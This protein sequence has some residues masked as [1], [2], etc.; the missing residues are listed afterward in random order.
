MIKI[1]YTLLF[2]AIL[3]VFAFAAVSP[4][5]SIKINNTVE[6]TSSDLPIFIINTNGQEIVDDPRI[7]AEMG[8][9]NNGPGKRNFL[10][11]PINGYNGRIAIEL[12]GSATGWYPKGQYRFETQDSL[13]ENLNVSLLGMP[14]END[15]I[16]Y[17]PYTDDQSLIRNVLAYKLSNDIGRYASR[18]RFCELVLDDD[19]RGLYI[20]MEKIKRDNDRVDIAKQDSIDIANGDI[21][22]GY[23]IKVDKWAGEN[24]GGWDGGNGTF[25][26]YHYPKADKIVQQQQDY[27]QNFM[28]SFENTM[29]NL[30]KLGGPL[31]GYEQY[32]DVPSFIDHFLLNEFAKNVDA[33]RIS[34]FLYKQHDSTGG[35]LFA[36]PAW[37]FNLSFGNSWYK[38]DRFVTDTWQ[39]DYSTHIRP[40]DGYRVPF[41]WPA[42]V[43]YPACTDRIVLRWNELK[44]THF[45]KNAIFSTIDVLADS[46]KE[47]R[48]R[49][50]ARWP[51]TEKQPYEDEITQ[52]KQ[53][54]SDRWDFMETNLNL[55][56]DVREPAKQNLPGRYTLGENYPN[57]FNPVTR[58][59]YE[60][61]QKARVRINI[62]NINGQVVAT[63]VDGLK[64]AGSYTVKFDAGHLASGIYMY[65][66][67]T[68]DFVGT[69]KMLLLR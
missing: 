10:T 20:L 11:D 56:S 26:Q 31:P 64:T 17:G 67:Q 3:T 22:G 53:W 1:I 39:V 37:D 36:G 32:I 51:E 29:L 24:V 33:Y 68:D 52:M 46:V 66:L 2:S 9:I 30:D 49:N 44:Y 13:G 55:L 19:Y 50:V 4:P 57:P 14:R 48:L 21:S 8:V 61:P 59:S 16:L 58:F 40:N 7:V 63:L 69:R 62:Y 38:E 5:A 45:D 65:T 25:Y 27:I 6:F 15:W 41:W 28:N 35:K 42:L 54:I 43:K 47:A 23:I 18:T 12:R 60:L 34:T